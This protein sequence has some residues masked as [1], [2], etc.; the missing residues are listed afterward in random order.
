MRFKPSQIK[1]AKATVAQSQTDSEIVPAVQGKKI[2]VMFATVQSDGTATAVT[3]NTKKSLVAGVA[4]T[5]PYPN[6]A[7]G[8]EVLPP[9]D[10]GWFETLPNESLT[11]TTGAGGST[12]ILVG[13]V[14]T[15]VQ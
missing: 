3:F 1:R 5:P 2:T 9:N 12:S 15:T 11:V 10:Y 7:N 13:Y 4:I 8:G 14:E 6:A